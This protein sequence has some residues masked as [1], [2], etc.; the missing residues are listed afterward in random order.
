MKTLQFG[1]RVDNLD[2]SIAFYTAMGYEVIG[3][4]PDSG[5]GHLAML[6]LP[7]DEFVTI[8]LVHNPGEAAVDGASRLSHFVIQVQSMDQTLRE[9]TARGIAAPGSPT[10]H[11]PADFLTTMISDPDGNQ[12]ELVQ[13]PAGHTDGMT[14][15]DWA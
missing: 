11:G 12:I 9:F 8:E 6:K 10:C 13:W 1:L 15:A 7:A 5:I 2:R 4:V 14:A 3:E